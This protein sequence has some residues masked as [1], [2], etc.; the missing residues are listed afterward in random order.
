MVRGVIFDLDG[1]LT[2]PIIDFK[3]IREAMGLSPHRPVLEQLEDLPAPVRREKEDILLA[4]EA[5]AA[6]ASELNDGVRGLVDALGRRGLAMAVST[7]NTASTARAV[8][9]RHGLPP[10]PLRSREDLPYKPSPAQV[11][12]LASEMAIEPSHLV[13]VGDYAFD[14]QAALAAGAWAVFLTNG[15]RP[16]VPTRY[17]YKI[18]AMGEFL[19]VIDAIEGTGIPAAAHPIREEGPGA[20]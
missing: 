13:V 12:S 3:A 14:T 6:A 2:R 4:Y 11:L 9:S 5:R 15:R 17:H 1:T 19:A 18:D 16:R 8:L 10:G 20:P 7:R